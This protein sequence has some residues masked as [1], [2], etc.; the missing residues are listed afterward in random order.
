[1]HQLDGAAHGVAQARRVVATSQGD[2]GT[3]LRPHPRAAGKHGMPHGRNQTRGR[4]RRDQDFEVV[5][6]GLLGAL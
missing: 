3:Q 6:E 4:L 5:G 1:M 2:G